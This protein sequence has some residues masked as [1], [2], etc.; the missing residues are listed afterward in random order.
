MGGKPLYKLP[1]DSPSVDLEATAHLTAPLGASVVMPVD[2]S[3]DAFEAAL[4]SEATYLEWLYANTDDIKT[5]SEGSHAIASA[6]SQIKAAGYAEV[7]YEYYDRIQTEVYEEM[8]AKYLADPENNPE[9][10]GVFQYN[11]DYK[12]V[13]GV[14]KLYSI[15][16]DTGSDYKYHAE[17]IKTCIKVIQIDADADGVKYA[18]NDIYNMWKSID[19]VINNAK[20]HHP[21]IVPSLYKLLEDGTAEM[22]D[23]SINKLV[24]FKRDDGGFS[25]S[26]NENQTAMYGSP[27]AMGVM[28]S[29]V[30]GTALICSMYRFIF[31]CLGYTPVPLCDY[32]DGEMFLEIITN[33]LPIE[34]IPRATDGPQTF[35]EMPGD[36]QMEQIFDGAEV[37][38]VTD[39]KNPA[40]T[41]LAYKSTPGESK[42]DSL[43]FPAFVSNPDAT[44][45]ILSFD[46]MID[47]ASAK[48][49]YQ[50]T[51]ANKNS[52]SYMIEILSKD[53]KLTIA[54]NVTTSSS[55]RNYLDVTINTDEW[56]NVRIEYYADD[57]KPAIKLYYNDKLILVSGAYFASNTKPPYNVFDFGNFFA[58]KA[59]NATVY[60]DNVY[61]SKVMKEYVEESVE[62]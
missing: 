14:L 28:E 60:L 62:P 15:F 18:A 7:T 35:D 21:D 17:K 38:I 10:S 46:M 5:N 40:N 58:L 29:D 2:A 31:E 51:M 22:I 24:K 49:H 55:S 32:R 8:K 54:E 44:C 6:W 52:K 34:K 37:E 4:K 3:T 25:I 19:L 48:P 27:V 61:A 16:S 20:K 9:P 56:F 59:T 30:N 47:S 23:N 43:R 53:D 36:S 1:T 45:W 26:V 12:A 13:W 57:T 42:G 50:I 33:A 39:P 11:A 41:V